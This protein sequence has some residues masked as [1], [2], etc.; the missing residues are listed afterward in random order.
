MKRVIALICALAVS[1]CDDQINADSVQTLNL[2]KPL[3]PT[4]FN[5]SSASGPVAGM[6]SA[7]A[8]YC[9]LT[10]VSGDFQGSG[11]SVQLNI[12]NGSWSLTGAA[13]SPGGVSASATCVPKFSFAMKS[14]KNSSLTAKLVGLPPGV[15]NDNCEMTSGPGLIASPGGKAFL[16]SG[17]KGRW[18]GAGE[19]LA[20]AES[21][22]GH[23]SLRVRG[24]DEGSGGWAMSYVL[25]PDGSPVRYFVPGG[26][27][28]DATTA[29]FTT[30]HSIASPQPWYWLQHLE[31]GGTGAP[32][33]VTMAPVDKAV[34][35]I[36]AISGGF[37]GGGE[38]V[39]ISQSGGNWVLSVDNQQSGGYVNVAALCVMREQRN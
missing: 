23:P 11:E 32:P 37:R 10:R 28:T 22:K 4:V 33:P 7:D 14:D 25:R 31:T 24:C 26:T 27:S 6:P 19:A 17:I 35:G 16:L 5:F 38:V 29:T 30:S 15:W 8:A 39:Q 2:T 9:F 12:V 34:C 13:L 1:G 20:V 36:T 3:Q 18:T 21:V